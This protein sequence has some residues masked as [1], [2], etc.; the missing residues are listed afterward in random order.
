[1]EPKAPGNWSAFSLTFVKQSAPDIHHKLQILNGFEGKRLAELIVS[2]EK[3][4]NNT[5]TLEDRQTKELKK[6]LKRQVQG[7][8]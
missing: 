5:E 4:F 6:A 3:V 8:T 7:I 2:V 1:M